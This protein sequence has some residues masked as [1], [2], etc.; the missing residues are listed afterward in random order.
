M[1]QT[2][3]VRL[4]VSM[5][6]S[7]I[8]GLERELHGKPAGLRTHMLVSVGCTL[9]M[10]FGV[11]APAI[12]GEHVS[13]DPSRIAA[14]I[15]TG[16]G[17]L[18]AGTIIRSVGSVHGLTTAASIWMVAAVGTAVGGG[19]FSGASLGTVMALLILWIGDSKYLSRLERETV[20]LELE[21][22]E[23]ETVSSRL[24]KLIADHADDLQS[25]SRRTRDGV[26][27]VTI[28]ITLSAR[29]KDQ[30]VGELG[31]THGIRLLEIS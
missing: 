14:Q 1:W 12:F 4:A 9:F 31:Q 29:D 25:I 13:V 30:L 5:L 6:L 23:S 22:D 10:L 19:F 8:I 21:F 3:L 17:F 20:I 11:N 15:V 24:D 7:A 18:G 2:V 16:V 26:S 27:A 28:K